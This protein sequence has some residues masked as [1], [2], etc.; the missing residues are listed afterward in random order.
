MAVKTT[1]YY[2]GYTRYADYLQCKLL[3]TPFASSLNAALNRLA[4]ENR[5]LGQVETKQFRL[6]DRI[7]GKCTQSLYVYLRNKTQQPSCCCVDGLSAK[8]GNDAQNRD[9][10]I[11]IS[12]IHTAFNSLFFIRQTTVVVYH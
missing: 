2:E 3:I 8:R 1:G 7:I 4:N 10:G 6:I 9:W 12:A 5:S 11:E